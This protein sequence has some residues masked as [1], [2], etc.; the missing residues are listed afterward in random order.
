MTDL[1]PFHG[2]T[3]PISS[4]IEHAHFLDINKN[5]VDLIFKVYS[6]ASVCGVV[7][8]HIQGAHFLGRNTFI[9]KKRDS[10]RHD[11]AYSPQDHDGTSKSVSLCTSLRHCVS[12][13]KGAT[14]ASVASKRVPFA[15]CL[16]RS[17]Y[18]GFR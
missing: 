6:I 17:S 14:E 1:I 11:E 13:V 10:E 8:L 16:K 5:C 7:Y 15:S 12:F 18:T 9:S 2:R 4:C 3:R